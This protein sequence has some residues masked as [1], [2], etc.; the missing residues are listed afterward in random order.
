MFRVLHPGLLSDVATGADFNG[1]TCLPDDYIFGSDGFGAAQETTAAFPAQWGYMM[2][3]VEG[4][5]LSMQSAWP[6]AHDVMLK[7]E[8]TSMETHSCQTC[9]HMI[10]TRSSARQEPQ[11]NQAQA[12]QTSTR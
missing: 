8:R 5:G 1:E 11:V 10:T 12:G 2:C 9:H 3:F 4:S 6:H 7:Q